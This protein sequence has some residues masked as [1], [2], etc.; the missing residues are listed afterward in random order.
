MTVFEDCLR[1]TIAAGARLLTSDEQWN[2][3]CRNYHY[4]RRHVETRVM[5]VVNV[6]FGIKYARGTAPANDECTDAATISAP[7]GSGDNSTTQRQTNY[8]LNGEASV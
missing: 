5:A 7:S 8:G 1:A 4:W 2:C 6:G 3:H